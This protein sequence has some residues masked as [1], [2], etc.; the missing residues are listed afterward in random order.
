MVAWFNFHLSQNAC[1]LVASVKPCKAFSSVAWSELCGAPSFFFNSC[2]CSRSKPAMRKGSRVKPPAALTTQSASSRTPSRMAQST[3]LASRGGSGD[4]VR[5]WPRAVS[6][7]SCVNA[8]SSTSSWIELEMAS[9]SGGSGAFA[10]KVDTFSREPICSSMSFAVSAESSSG[11][12]SSSGGRNSSTL[13]KRSRQ[14]RWKHRPPCV[15]PARPARC[16]ADAREIHE[17]V[18]VPTLRY[19]S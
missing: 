12:R 3:V 18:S 15:R 11:L 9:G 19:G 8:P 13:P 1:W 10:R 16:L 2:T 5:C 4:W 7:S 6:C 14:K 17:V